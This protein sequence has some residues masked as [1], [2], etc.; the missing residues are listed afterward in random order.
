[1]IPARPALL[2][3]LACATA[4]SQGVPLRLPNGLSATL[5]EDHEAPLIRV[6]GCLPVAPAE[7]PPGLP[8]LP[9]LLWSTLTHS[10]RGNRSAAEFQ[11]LAEG[12]A[13]RLELRP[14]GRGL[15]LSLVC[16]SRDQELAFGLLGDLLARGSLDPTQLEA[17]RIRLH[18]ESREAARTRWLAEV[19][20]S[21]LL[22][23]P[24]ATLAKAGQADLEA[25]QLRLF[26]PERLHL[27]LQGDLNP[28]QAQQLLLLALGAW[29]PGPAQP[30][31][32]P[33]PPARSAELLLPEAPGTVWGA[34]PPLPAGDAA[35]ALLG[36]LLPERLEG[37]QGTGRPGDPWRLRSTA[38]SPAEALQALEARLAVLTFS[39]ADVESA[40]RAWRGQRALAGLDP[41]LSLEARLEGP[42]S[43]A[44][45][46]RVTASDLQR[47]YRALV[48]P[49]ARHLLWTGDAGWLKQV[50]RP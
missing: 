42:P 19:S 32:P 2:L 23:P 50:P 46:A 13:I 9:T 43:E 25:L 17:A 41:A 7:V 28:T 27:E 20:G 38:A 35:G 4:S 24:E 29:R 8:G 40:R 44:A 48:S 37:L 36:L 3:A 1:M 21:A 34:L 39:E 30:L 16:R 6:E 26:R 33:P 18:R 45:V 15:R 49:D 12:S 14:E 10:P 5:T 31:P 11:T 22:P 47:A